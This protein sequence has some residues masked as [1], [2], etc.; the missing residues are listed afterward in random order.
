V[1]NLIEGKQVPLYGDGS[2]S[3]LAAR[4]RSLRRHHGVLGRGHVGEVYNIGRHHEVT[5]RR[6]TEIVL[7]LMGKSWETSVRYVKDAPAMIAGTRSMHR[8]SAGVGL[9]AEM[10]IR[11][12]ASRRPSS[13]LG[14][15]RNGGRDIKT[16]S[17]QRYYEQQYRARG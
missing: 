4:G 15:T 5:N 1:T 2:T 6:I 7:E 17:I 8:R 3:G 9:G 11:R 14:R 12:A 13:G 10:D 16:G